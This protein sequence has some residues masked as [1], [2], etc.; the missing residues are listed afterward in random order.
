MTQEVSIGNA[1]KRS[2][3]KVPTIRYYEQVGLYRHRPAPMAIAASM[4]KRPCGVWH[5]SG[6]PANWVSTSMRFGSS[7]TYPTSPSDHARKP[8]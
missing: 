4:T 8:T 2:G 1:A 5:S 6:T 3:V 7:S